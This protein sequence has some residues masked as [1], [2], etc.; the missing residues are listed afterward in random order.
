[1]GGTPPQRLTDVVR[2]CCT[3]DADRSGLIADQGS[4]PLEMDSRSRFMV[5]LIFACRDLYPA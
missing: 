3:V 1:M 4:T 5:N 2:L